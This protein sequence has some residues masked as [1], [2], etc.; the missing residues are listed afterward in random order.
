[1]PPTTPGYISSLVGPDLHSVYIET[2]EELKLEYPLVLNVSDMPYNP[3]TDRNVSGLGTMPAKG[4]NEQFTRDEIIIGNTKSY[5]ATPY[6]L[7]TEIT[8][9]AWEDELYGVMREMVACLARAG[10][11]REEI[12]AF[13]VL[14]NAFS[15]TA[16]YAG[17]DSAAL[18]STSHTLLNGDTA[19][20]RPNPD[21]GLSVTGLQAGIEAFHAMVDHRGLPKKM[22]PSM[23]VISPQNMWTAREILGSG[24]VP[25]S[26]DNEP[27][28]LNAET[29]RIVVTHYLTT[30]T[31][32]FLMAEKGIHDLNF[33]WRTRP[34]FNTFDDNYTMN[35]IC[36]AYQR[37][38]KGHGTWQGVYGSTGA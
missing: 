6:G 32:W 26:G 12:D 28:S 27:N 11:N 15:S 18:C 23:L 2:G 31:Y 29:M 9:E 5:E 3:I 37:H 36:T 8:F 17:F 24:A 22:M 38:T 35:A 34:K 30:S 10:R 16:P 25:Y 33:L 14:N 20:N 13:A 1:M 4:I 7:A 21:V 19:S